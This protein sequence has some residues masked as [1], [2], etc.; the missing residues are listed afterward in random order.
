MTI[1]TSAINDQFCSISF[2]E[3]NTATYMFQGKMI[4][5]KETLQY[6]NRV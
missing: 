2:T 1:S 4:F 6:H 5:T 3:N